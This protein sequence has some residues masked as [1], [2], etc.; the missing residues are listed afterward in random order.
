VSRTV[1]PPLLQARIPLISQG[2][3]EDLVG[4]DPGRHP[5]K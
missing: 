1:S 2:L 3:F 5:F 4:D